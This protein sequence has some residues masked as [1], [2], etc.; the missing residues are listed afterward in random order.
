MVNDLKRWSY[1]KIPD[2]YFPDF[3]RGFFEADGSVYWRKSDCYLSRGRIVSEIAQ[4]NKE[5]L[6]HIHQRLKDLG[7]VKG[8]GIHSYTVCW[9]LIFSVYDSISLYHFM[10][11]NSGELY[12]QRKK[13]QFEK[14]IER[15]QSQTHRH[16]SHLKG[17]AFC[18]RDGKPNQ[19]MDDEA[20]K[21]F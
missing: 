3:L 6:E 11:D 5:M 20:E 15:Q 1:Y 16:P 10:Y 21:T 14:L 8:G 9:R 4:A 17:G 13:L 19:N 2:N 12:L 7:V 18:A